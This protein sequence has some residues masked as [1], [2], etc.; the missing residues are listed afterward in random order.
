MAFWLFLPVQY[1]AFL[2]VIALVWR[3]HGLEP[4]LA[5]ALAVTSVLAFVGAH[6]VPFGLLPYRGGDPLAISWA[7]VFVPMAVALVTLAV[8]LRLRSA[9]RPRAHGD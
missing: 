8:A 5:S 6:L 3:R 1:S 7:L 9:D 4:T 2:A